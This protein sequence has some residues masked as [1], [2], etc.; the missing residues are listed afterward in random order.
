M[1]R[2]FLL[3]LTLTI[4]FSCIPVYAE[5][6]PEAV[7]DDPPAY[8]VCGDTNRDNTADI[9]DAMLTLRI[10]QRIITL[11]DELSYVCADTNHDYTVTTVDA[12][13]LLRK[14]MFN[15]PSHTC[16]RIAFLN[17]LFDQMGK[18]YVY[19]DSGPDSFDC[20]GLVYYCLNRGG[21]TI[22]RQSSAM[23]A[24]NENWEYISSIDEL[25]PGDLMFFRQADE[26]RITH[27][28][29]YIGN[30]LLLHASS[31]AGRVVISSMT[32]WYL[33][34]FRWGRRVDF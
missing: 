30:N 1:K 31:S 25:V 14:V 33:T 12:L 6:Q 19:G 20:S 5:T 18:P 26:S 21:Y 11:P 2:V 15:Q 8:L 13:I 22:S 23:Y 16:R 27:V 7:Y 10:A 9:I 3:F 4:C 34:N 32:N 24:A 17:S 29:V 28:G